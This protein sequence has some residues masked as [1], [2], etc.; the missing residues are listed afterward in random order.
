MS[1]SDRRLSGRGPPA[2]GCA[3]R[4]P[5]LSVSKDI[6]A[7]LFFMALGVLGLGLGW[8][9][10]YGTAARMG[11]GF[12]PK[13]LCWSLIGMGAGVLAIALLQ[14]G[15]AMDRWHLRPLV[16]VLASVLVFGAL[17]ETGGLVP[18]TI[19]MVLTAAIGS[20]ET[21]WLETIIVSLVLAGASVLIFVKAL[22]L[23]MKILPGQ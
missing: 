23:T 1:N 14:R 11:P 21:R 2:S 3:W 5:V 12:V 9:Y 7:G 22:G 19:G 10:V 8:N 13:L 6:L 20:T 4:E 16:A 15:E 17:I 18:A